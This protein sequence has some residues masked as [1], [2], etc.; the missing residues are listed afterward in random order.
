M[1]LIKAIVLYKLLSRRYIFQLTKYEHKGVSESTD[2]DYTNFSS[3]GLAEQLFL[4]HS[5]L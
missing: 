3:V 4:K 5:K 1:L 2:F